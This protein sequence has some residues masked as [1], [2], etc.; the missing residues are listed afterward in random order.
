MGAA[1][2]GGHA[3][4]S[5]DGLPI[6][7]ATAA[8]TSATAPAPSAAFAGLCAV[9]HTLGWGCCNGLVAF[10]VVRTQF[11]FVFGRGLRSEL[12]LLALRRTTLAAATAASAPASAPPAAFPVDRCLFAA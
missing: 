8:A 1:V 4:G 11:H 12:R 7:L 10:V 2:F 3:F 5:T 9:L 6:A